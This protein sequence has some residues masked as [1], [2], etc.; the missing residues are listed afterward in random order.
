MR[1]L[2]HLHVGQA[3]IRVGSACW[4]L[5]CLEHG[6]QAD[7][8]REECG[9][10]DVG[11]AIFAEAPEARF[12][13]RCL[14]V[15]TEPDAM[16]E[17]LKGTHCGLFGQ[18][19]LIAGKRSSGGAYSAGKCTHGKLYID[20]IMDRARILAE[21]CDCLDGFV[22][23]HACAGGAGSGLGAL[24][25]EQLKIE[26]G[27]Q[28]NRVATTI[29]PS[30]HRASSV[31]EP[32]N[33]VLCSS[34]LAD[35]A[36]SIMLVDNEAVFDICAKRLG[37]EQPSFSNINRL[38]AQVAS[39]LTAPMRFNNGS[40]ESLTDL[41]SC[42]T[43]YSRTRWLLPSY[44]PLIG[45]DGAEAAH[46]PSVPAMTIN[47][48]EGASRLI[49]CDPR[50]C[51]E[52]ACRLIYRGDVQPSEV[53]APVA[54]MARHLSFVDW[55]PAG[56]QSVISPR[57][58]VAVPGGDLARVS[59]ACCLLSNSSAVLQAFSHVTRRFDAMYTKRAF[60]CYY[61]ADGME[62]GEFS[63]AR[64]N[65][66]ALEKDYET[67]IAETEAGHDEEEEQG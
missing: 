56:L 17:V 53:V 30:P 52:L 21:S 28:K 57:P 22:M 44:A 34:I 11:S 42:M 6:I 38:L 26:Y 5:Y 4:E 63:E 65:L 35:C 19:Q 32:F 49:K 7:G 40:T 46:R 16:D 45:T 36:T 10:H 61:V 47:A 13:P 3:G 39:S 31:V 67:C 60:V 54:I 12:V 51:K 64:E 8:S 18:E 59:R 58:P 1:D 20:A 41:A 55:A 14:F 9:P 37:V 33:A 23:Q 27:K 29:W 25:L 24:L 43:P 66:A 15:D 62:E 2:I 50:G 48:F